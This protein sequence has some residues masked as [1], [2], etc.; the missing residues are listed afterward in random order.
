MRSGRRWGALG[1]VE[2]RGAVE[3][4]VEELIGGQETGMRMEKVN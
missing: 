1:D 2:G 3:V 4:A